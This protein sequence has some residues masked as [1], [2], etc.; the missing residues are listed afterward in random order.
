MDKTYSQIFVD[1]FAGYANYL[2]KQIT[3]PHWHNYFYSLIALTAI[4]LIWE[5][6]F[7][8]Q[9]RAFFRKD[10]WLDTFYIFFNFFI[11]S[12]IGYNALSDVF[13]LFFKDILG[14]IGINNLA[15]F[16]IANWPK[17]AQLLVLF[18]VRDF[19]QWNIHRMLHHIPVL[20][21]FHKI[22]HSV[23][24][25]GVASHLRY[26]FAETIIYRFFEYIPLA[27]IGFGINDFFYCAH[28]YLVLGAF[29]SCQYS[30]QFG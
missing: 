26:H 14:T 20:W 25:M 2:W 27:M 28:V 9:K 4:V 1:S 11:F 5:M 22:H 17:W 29:E 13:V 3:E 16:Y 19:I 7:P 15:V 21:Q 30:S 23:Q 12:L 6:L 8:R 10:F 18:I 24:Q